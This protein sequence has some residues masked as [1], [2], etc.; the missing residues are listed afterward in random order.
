MTVSAIHL[1]QQ[2][3]PDKTVNQSTPDVP[4]NRVLSNEMSQQQNVP[5][6][7]VKTADK[8]QHADTQKQAD[9]N[10]TPLIIRIAL[11]RNKPLPMP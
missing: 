11:T 2:A 4:F 3:S 9:K 7:S 5:T 8:A 10:P 1:L 6:A